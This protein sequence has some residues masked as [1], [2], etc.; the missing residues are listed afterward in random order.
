MS[1]QYPNKP[2]YLDPKQVIAVRRTPAPRS[3][4]TRTGYGKRLATSWEL[5]LADRRWRRVLVMQYSNAGSAYVR[6][7][8]KALFLG[9][10]EPDT[11]KAPAA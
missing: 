5:Q 4:Q 3:G 11:F 7:G 8:G 2:D 1:G 6:V 10:F 9:T